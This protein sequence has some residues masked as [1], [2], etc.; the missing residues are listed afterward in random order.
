MPSFSSSSDTPLTPQHAELDSLRRAKQRAE[1]DLESE[2]NETLKLREELKEVRLETREANYRVGQAE[3]VA[4]EAQETSRKS[5]EAYNM[6][7]DQKANAEL[8]LNEVERKVKEQ[9]GEIKRLSYELEV[10][11]VRSADSAAKIGQEKQALEKRVHQL[12]TE[13]GRLERELEAAKSQPP[14]KEKE[15]V[16]SRIARPP[17]RSSAISPDS[18][19]SQPQPQTRFG[20]RPTPAPS[21]SSS[22]SAAS[23]LPKATR[24]PSSL[25]TAPARPPSSLGSATSASSL[26]PSNKGIPTLRRGSV[27]GSSATPGGV[28]TSSSSSS[29]AAASAAAKEKEKLGHLESTL[30]DARLSIKS[31]ES[32]LLVSESTI[33]TLQTS[34]EAAET[35]LRSKGEELLKVENGLMALERESREVIEGL[36]EE[37]D[38]GREELEGVRGEAEERVREMERGLEEARRE[39]DGL[40]R[41]VKQLREALEERGE[42][43]EGVKEEFER[44]LREA[45]EEIEAWK[46][47]N[48]EM[49]HELAWTE[50]RLAAVQDDLNRV[51][52]EK[53][54]AE[55][56][57]E[58]V[59]NALEEVEEDNVR[60][61]GRLE[62]VEREKEGLEKR[63]GEVEA[64]VKRREEGSMAERAAEEGEG[65]EVGRLKNA[66]R[67]AEVKIEALEVERDTL[68]AAVEAHTATA[69][70]HQQEKALLEADLARAVQ[71][72]KGLLTVHETLQ[73]DS[74]AA[75]KSSS[76]RIIELETELTTISADLVYKLAQLDQLSAEAHS[77][78]DVEA[79][80]AELKSRLEAKEAEA[81]RAV[82]ALEEG[83]TARLAALRKKED[84]LAGLRAQLEEK[85]EEIMRLSIVVEQ[86]ASSASAHEA[87][88]EQA[89]ALSLDVAAKDEEI[90]RLTAAIDEAASAGRS[91]VHNEDK[92]EQLASLSTQLAS[93]EAE[94]TNLQERLKEA[95]APEWGSTDALQ[96]AESE[97]TSLRSQILSL[98][99]ALEAEKGLATDAKREAA[100]VE[101]ALFD[102]RHELQSTNGLL[103]VES[104]AKKEAEH[105]VEVLRAEINE[106][107]LSVSGMEEME[108]EIAVVSQELDQLRASAEDAS[109][110]ALQ[111]VSDL[112]QRLRAQETAAE[113]LERKAVE[114][115]ALRTVLRA[116][117]EQVDN[118]GWQLRETRS[119]ASEKAE[120]MDEKAKGL[121]DRAEAAEADADRLRTEVDDLRHRLSDVQDSL[122]DAQAD[123]AA[124]TSAAATRA[125]ASPVP[126]TPSPNTPSF[127]LNRSFT[128]S[129]D[130]DPSVLILRLREERDELRHRLDF[131][132]T[133]SRFRTEELQ[134][135]LRQAE[136][137][138]AEEISSLR[139]DLMDKQVAFESECEQNA[140]I[141]EALKEARKE[142]E[143]V[144]EE[145]E[146]KERRL[147]EVEGQV[148]MALRALEQERSK[149]E[150]EREE[151]DEA[152]GLEQELDAATQSAVSSRKELVV[153]TSANDELRLSLATLQD[154]LASAL[155]DVETHKSVAAAAGQRIDELEAALYASKQ[156]QERAQ[157]DGDSLA[158]FA[159][160]CETLQGDKEG[161]RVKIARQDSLISHYQSKMALLQLNLAVR[162]AIED[163]EGLVDET[164]SSA[165]E[166]AQTT[167]AAVGTEPIDDMVLADELRLLQEQ[168]DAALGNRLTLEEEL[169]TGQA[170]LNV[171]A[172]RL[173]TSVHALETT[174]SA[175]DELVAEA[176]VSAE[177]I[178]ELERLIDE[179]EQRL[180]EVEEALAAAEEDK[181]R[182]SSALE[183]E[184]RTSNEHLDSVMTLRLQL[185]DAE[186]RAAEFEEKLE[187]A[188]VELAGAQQAAL[189]Q[190]GQ[191]E[192]GEMDR[193]AENAGT[194]EQRR[195]LEEKVEELQA[196]H[197]AS[198]IALAESHNE[199][200]SLS[201]RLSG[202]NNDLAATKNAL[203]DTN[204]TLTDLRDRLAASPDP[205]ALLLQVSSLEAQ[206]ERLQ[207]AV[208]EKTMVHDQAQSR[209]RL[210]QEQLAAT[211]S[212]RDDA[213]E[214]LEATEESARLAKDQVDT[215]TAAC[216]QARADL[217]AAQ[218]E[219]ASLASQLVQAGE[220]SQRTADLEQQIVAAQLE[221]Q[222]LAS[223]VDQERSV[224]AEAQASLD[225]AGAKAQSAAELS[226]REIQTLRKLSKAAQAEAEALAAEASGLRRQVEDLTIYIGEVTETSQRALQ[227]AKDEEQKNV[228]EVIDH[229]Q[230]LELDKAAVEEQV[231]ILEEQIQELSKMPVK[232][233]GEAEAR[234]AELEKV[235]QAKML[236][237]EEADE[238]LIDALKTQ[239]RYT[240]QIE[241]LKAKIATLQR[242]LTAAKAAPPPLPVVE[243]PLPSAPAPPSSNKKRR[244]PQ[245]FDSLP[246]AAPRAIVA[247]SLP[248]LDQENTTADA[249]RRV[250]RP[251]SPKKSL[252]RDSTVPLKPEHVPV[253]SV[254]G[255]PL[256]P[257]DENTPFAPCLPAAAKAAPVSK[258]NSLKT[259]LRAQREAREASA[260]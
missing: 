194:D 127:N 83:A 110:A 122:H 214:A 240:A 153:A 239:K 30:T 53:K 113:D 225:D 20:F 218:A 255:K 8:A 165:G 147:K 71:E 134:S 149:R 190:R 21:A 243:I 43:E 238:K 56:Q 103:A 23:G 41:E 104:R 209:L 246:S 68:I 75:S 192:T 150:E 168:L 98:E 253:F 114:S 7:K 258:V 242:D 136:E 91:V 244:V 204:S 6:L 170:Q 70:S 206:V 77:R 155:R 143:R 64:E 82:A 216:D 29:A 137:T 119:T 198:Q 106:L 203:D 2:R 183:A 26:P 45:E 148:E 259:R 141:E 121:L 25:G 94:L 220:S 16:Q 251:R 78:E 179:I 27:S 139:M 54:E 55:E 58:G 14:V 96:V 132:R 72:L 174:Q 250:P 160:L 59:D 40:E 241:R 85:D 212:D 145:L 117:E 79:T 129:P 161:S 257:L 166:V 50:E 196:A 99:S 260:G 88:K 5:R 227:Q 230:T 13:V 133:E 57:L 86:A 120:E 35:K 97:A 89:R 154:D 213:R 138:K 116:T 93:T 108:R 48:E 69:A 84:D 157:Q 10:T 254:P 76:A 131:A 102:A 92:D 232:T 128:F 237:V 17:S 9:D 186:E 90:A 205:E 178:V 207:V 37:V 235:L 224:A 95:G 87:I 105:E 189:E 111:E 81:S 46:E 33:S 176:S 1:Q 115:D 152:W 234:A 215:L 135:R 62:E 18:Q 164:A 63:V 182:L 159:S 156:Q 236:D 226:A 185:E 4:V 52:G 184:T 200:A 202:A 39:R 177:H 219:S 19:P 231:R 51:E 125:A 151:R 11:S 223:L 221:A 191:V 208:E 247:S 163:D 252:S 74:I 118:L 175:N 123:L 144:G 195:Q 187:K 180:A 15:G 67:E 47:E 107:Y 233:N 36:R 169:R 142:R 109:F 124:S 65:D 181:A 44:L 228:A 80:V 172:S 130:A 248:A 188:T 193:Q 173:E 146:G 158:E 100:A 229:C 199:I 211:A 34:L 42:E 49:E 61:V 38:E 222:T 12:T 73:S 167:D 201:S 3:K 112:Q 24:P 171:V 217:A 101:E 28:N 245:D 249:S 66:M 126:S 32:S 140:K 60:L 256:Q 197:A 162:V 31:L 210:V 22:S